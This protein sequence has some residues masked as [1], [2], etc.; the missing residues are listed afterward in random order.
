MNKTDFQHHVMTPQTRE[1]YP[2]QIKNVWGNVSDAEN[3]LSAN[4]GTTILRYDGDTAPKIILDLG[5][6]ST[7]GYPVFKVKSFGGTPVLRLA[8]SDWYDYIIDAQ[9]GEIGDFRRGCCK[10]LGVELPVLP[11]DPNRFNLFTI[12]HN[13]LYLSPLIQGQQRWLML[14]LDTPGT[15]VELEYVY[16]HYTSNMSEHDGFFECSDKDLTKLWYA[17]TW[18]CQIATLENS[19]SWDTLCG[20]LLLRALTKGHDAGIYKEGTS[21]TDYTVTFEGA[22]A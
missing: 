11:G 5:E 17:S 9:Y 12:S 1:C 7:G 15:F 22:I 20:T 8:Y 10:Y 13:G 19:Q 16:I 14:K 2:K 3:L 18:T 4:K 6:A 21:L